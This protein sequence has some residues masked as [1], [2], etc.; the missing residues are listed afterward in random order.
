MDNHE[1]TEKIVNR[2]SEKPAKA[3]SGFAM[4]VVVLAR[5]GSISFRP[6][7]DHIH[8]QIKKYYM[9]TG[10]M[11]IF[12]DV[13]AE[14]AIKDVSVNEPLAPNVSYEAAKDWYKGWL[15]R[16]NGGEEA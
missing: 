2:Y 11:L 13:Y 12:P 1:N 5:R 16:N 3:Y 6:S 15:S 10:L 9:N 8:R 4:L 7:F 14:A